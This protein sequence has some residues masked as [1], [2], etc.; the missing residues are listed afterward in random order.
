MAP[1]SSLGWLCNFLL[2]MHIMELV[3]FSLLF[4]IGS[5]GFLIPLRNLSWARLIRVV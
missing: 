4:I 1:E 2:G 5:R 3:A